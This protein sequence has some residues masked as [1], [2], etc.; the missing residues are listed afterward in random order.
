[1]E[2][3]GESIT[4]GTVFFLVLAV[5]LALFFEAINGFHDTANAVATV[6]YTHS[7]KPSYAVVWSGVWNLIGVMLSAGTVAFGIVALLP[8][9]LVINV[10]SGPSY[11]MV[12]SL[13]I[14]AIIW[15]F[16]TW[17]LGLP[18]SSTHALVGA[19]MGVGLAHSVISSGHSLSQGINWEQVKQVFSSLLI[20]P[21]IGF[22]GAGLLLLLAKALLKKPQL[23]QPADQKQAPPPWIRGLLILTCTS[24]SFA[25]GS[26]DG[27]KGMGLLVLILV[28]IL[29]GIFSL[30]LDTNAATIA[31]LAAVSS[32]VMPVI[33]HH[34]PKISLSSQDATNELTNFL[35]QQSKASDKTFA[36]LS[37]KSQEM[38]NSLSGKTSF[39]AFASNDRRV[40][41]SNMYFIS[42][43]IGKL[44]KQNQL[45]DPK[46]KQALV[47][48]QKLLDGQTKFIPNFVKTAV[49]LALGIGTMVGWKRVVVT[50]GEKIG[51]QHLSYGQGAAAEIVAAVTIGTLDRFGLPVSTTHVLSSGVAGTMAANGSGLQ[52]NTIRNII[53]AWVLTLPACTLLGASVFSAAFYLVLHSGF[54]VG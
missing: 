51:K 27:Q 48:Y 1:M 30:N 45:T 36:A 42:S 11:A 20:S 23:Y 40:L 21:I 41:R 3:F 8:V 7:L 24:V 46:E 47:S 33:E 25:H 14:S 34:A 17:F 6:I 44:N 31:Q 2:L 37:N 9:E 53:L 49:A 10:G 32:S 28:G 54:G 13:L 38:A 12:F 15:N 5:G 22:C 16:G 39:K 29:P 43:A 4:I 50:V 18:N 35:D 19:I 26:N 52:A